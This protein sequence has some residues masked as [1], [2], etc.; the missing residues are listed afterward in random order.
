MISILIVVC[1]RQ[2]GVDSYG[3]TRAVN[4]QTGASR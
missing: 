3:A 4:A 2:I 1:L